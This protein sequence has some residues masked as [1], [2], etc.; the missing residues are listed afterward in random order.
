ML[1]KRAQAPRPWVQATSSLFLVKLSALTL[2]LGR[3]PRIDQA[4]T[5]AAPLQAVQTMIPFSVPR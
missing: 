1:L 2:T 4:G 3:L 5:G